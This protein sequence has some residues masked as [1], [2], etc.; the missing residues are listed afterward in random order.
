MLVK[1][2]RRYCGVV[3]DLSWKLALMEQYPNRQPNHPNARK[4]K[5][6][7][8]KYRDIPELATQS[9]EHEARRYYAS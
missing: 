9:C 1:K 7:S 4:R 2:S 3:T 5:E 6:E 8:Q